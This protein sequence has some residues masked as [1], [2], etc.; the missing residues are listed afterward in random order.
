[1]RTGKP[2]DTCFALI[3]TTPVYLWCGNWDA[4]QQVLEQL[5]GHT[6]WPVLR[7]FHATALAMQGALLIG[8]EETERGTEMLLEALPK[9]RAE[10]QT[11]V[12]S[13]AAC[14]VA[15]GLTTAGRA[16][17]ALAVILSVRRDCRRNGETVL[18]PELLRLQANA[19]LSISQANKVR[20]VRLLV[21]SCGIA[22]RQSAPSWEL[23]STITLAL[24]RIQ[25]GDR[26]QARQLLS[27]IYDQFTEGSET[28]DLR[29]AAT[30]LRELD[31]TCDFGPSVGEDDRVV[32]AAPRL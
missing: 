9:M 20:A 18:L 2:L 27:A 21:R 17:E 19:L 10:R 16:E 14:S 8:R 7:P 28:R 23:R 32:G 11:A 6:H 31:R 29:A 13:F 25:Q 22:R 4:A 12:T 24:I 5:I 15:D 1:M 3:F 26:E 30:M